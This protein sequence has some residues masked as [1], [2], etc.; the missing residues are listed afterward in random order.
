MAPKAEASSAV[1]WR[2]GLQM[3]EGRAQQQAVQDFYKSSISCIEG[4][5]RASA[6]TITR[7][8]WRHVPRGAQGS[9][10]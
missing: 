2:L 5:A 1:V 7:R 8:F 9:D 10:S 3:V 6:F 4:S